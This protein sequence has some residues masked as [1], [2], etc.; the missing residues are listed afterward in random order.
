MLTEVEP[1][2]GRL[3]HV[4]PLIFNILVMSTVVKFGLTN[5]SIEPVAMDWREIKSEISVPFTSVSLY[6]H[7]HIW[8]L[9]MHFKDRFR[10]FSSI[11]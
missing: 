4:N 6:V 7:S 3:W 5:W 2:T 1:E 11:N 10:F 9:R 8:E